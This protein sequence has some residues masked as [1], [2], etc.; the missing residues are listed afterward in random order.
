MTARLLLLEDSPDDRILIIE[1]LRDY[2]LEFESECL[3]S[4][5]SLRE[6]LAAHPWDAVLCDYNMPGLTA[7]EALEIVRLHDP[8]LPFILVSGTVDVPVAVRMMRQG[9]HEYVMKDQL[10]R[11]GPAVEREIR[12]SR[13]RRSEKIAKAELFELQK[14]FHDTFEQSSIGIAHL[15]RDARVI[16]SN[17]RLAEML[18]FERDELPGLPC[19]KLTWPEDWPDEQQRQRDL[20]DGI[21][22]EYSTEKRYRRRDGTPIWTLL[23]V[24]AIRDD[25]ERVSY[26]SAVVHEITEQKQAEENVRSGER[27]TRAILDSLPFQVAV[28][29]REGTVRHVN[30]AWDDPELPHSPAP[31]APVGIGSS[32]LATCPPEVSE[33]LRS[34]LEGSADSVAI[35]YP[36]PFEERAKW[37]LMKAAPLVWSE[38]GAVVSRID[39]TSRVLAEQKLARRELEYRS[40]VDTMSDGLLDIDVDGRLL[41]ANLRFCEMIGYEP[42][43]LVGED[44]IDML[45]PPSEQSR[46]REHGERAIKGSASSFQTPVVHRDGREIWI[47]VRT[48]PR[49]N[50]AGEVAGRLS[51]VSDITESRASE[52][53]QDRLRKQIEELNRIESLGKL[54]GTMAHEF[55]NV[56]MGILP[57]TEV[58]R[59]SA[60]GNEKIQQAAQFIAGAVDRGQ[61]ISQEILRFARPMPLERSEIG[62][63]AL[64]REVEQTGQGVVGTRHHLKVD[65]ANGIGKIA[66]D[67]E[68]LLQVFTNL[69]I[70]ARDAMDPG[71]TVCISVSRDETDTRY[72]FGVIDHP[73]RYVHVA[74]SDTGN[75][76]APEII[77]HIFEPMFTT[78]RTGTGLGLAIVY[79][80][81][82][83]HD[84]C[85]FAESNP[86]EG[87]TMHLFLPLSS[88]DS[89]SRNVERISTARGAQ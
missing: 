22:S 8:D 30:A 57:F 9:M 5:D 79:Q 82:K 64:L 73:E 29:D 20:L 80:I 47:E 44:L 25:E 60:E 51:V 54:A 43:D 59:R 83:A 28:L 61:R 3:E 40:L 13:H 31:G 66:A 21:I 85:I 14:R 1:S 18:G 35:E 87:T 4:R 23:T 39:I 55:N 17:Q 88:S 26:L 10:E 70:N 48:A 67:R 19:E 34:I 69:T 33:P 2:G 46:V 53:E 78:K 41:F 37:F 72:G 12:D 62:I 89:L 38:R 16:W 7:E 76:I 63:D 74:V 45:I 36:C 84:G 65:R 81:I 86:G 77:H 32:Y 27:F 56:L 24:T 50:S 11:L 58:I 75:G 42:S 68:Q 49:F 71:G 6:M 15:D 52:Q